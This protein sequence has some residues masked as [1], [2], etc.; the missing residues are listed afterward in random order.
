MIRNIKHQLKLQE[1]ITKYAE[2][3]NAEWITI[4]ETI[5]Y[6]NS[7]Y[8]NSM[9]G[10][11][12]GE[13]PTKHLSDENMYSEIELTNYYDKQII[14]YIFAD[15]DKFRVYHNKGTGINGSE[16]VEVVRF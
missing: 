4:D 11:G 5:Q 8:Q 12:V 13:E 9:I 15:S 14:F 7:H 10:L 16:L 3:C 6:K 1:L 2:K